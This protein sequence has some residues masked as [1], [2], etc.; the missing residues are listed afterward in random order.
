MPTTSLSAS[1]KFTFL[2]VLEMYASSLVKTVPDR[3]CVAAFAVPARAKPAL[4]TTPITAAPISP[5]L[6]VTLG[7][8][9]MVDG[10]L[11]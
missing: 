1:P 9:C 5:L 4:T 2:R 8:P 10:S 7:S 6:A 3:R 11:V